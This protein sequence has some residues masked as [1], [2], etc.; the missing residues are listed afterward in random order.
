MYILLL[1]D[2]SL[3]EINISGA[4]PFALSQAVEHAATTHDENVTRTYVTNRF[5]IKMKQMVTDMVL[6]LLMSVLLRTVLALLNTEE[7]PGLSLLPL[8]SIALGGQDSSEKKTKKQELFQKSPNHR[9]EARIPFRSW[10]S[11]DR[12][13]WLGPERKTVYSG[14]PRDGVGASPHGCDPNQTG[15]PRFRVGFFPIVH[16]S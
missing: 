16:S 4:T 14:E 11:L 7:E 5:I 8:S 2:R 10:R 12:K 6:D 3:L 1:A 13:L 9:K 15:E